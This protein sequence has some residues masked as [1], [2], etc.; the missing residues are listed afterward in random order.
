[1]LCIGLRR[2][3]RALDLG[4]SLVWQWFFTFSKVSPSTAA[5]CTF[6][7]GA[8]TIELRKGGRWTVNFSTKVRFLFSLLNPRFWSLEQQA[9]AILVPLSL[10]RAVLSYAVLDPS[11]ITPLDHTI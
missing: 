2:R 11:C 9:L 3:R 5:E 1:M 6:E 10:I 8:G 4:W 7:R